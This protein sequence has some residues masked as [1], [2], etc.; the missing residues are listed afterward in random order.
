MDKTLTLKLLPAALICKGFIGGMANCNYEIYLREVVNASAFLEE[1]QMDP[2]T[3]HR[4][5][6]RAVSG[7]AFLT[8]TPWILN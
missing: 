7:I 3:S 8:D 1:N 2:N 5:Q 4:Q 6:N